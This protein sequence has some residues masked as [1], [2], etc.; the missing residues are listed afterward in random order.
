MLL[1]LQHLTEVIYQKHPTNRQWQAHLLC[2]LLPKKQSGQQAR[3][4]SGTKVGVL[5]ASIVIS[6]KHGSTRLE[7]EAAAAASSS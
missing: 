3:S 7:T 1:P 2:R 4:N 5:T 6:R